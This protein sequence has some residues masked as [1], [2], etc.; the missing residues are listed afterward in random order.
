MMLP[1]IT[2]WSGGEGCVRGGRGRGEGEGRL[3]ACPLRTE[4][5]GE[6]LLVGNPIGT[7]G[8]DAG[9][10]SALDDGM[11]VDAQLRESFEETWAALHQRRQLR[12]SADNNPL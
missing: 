7:L 10:A 1:G 3:A 6:G 4:L 8:L 5:L 2:Y 9:V 12:A 11:V